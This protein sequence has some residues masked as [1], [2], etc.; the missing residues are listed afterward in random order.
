MKI[1]NTAQFDV[2]IGDGAGGYLTLGPADNGP[3][4]KTG[5]PCELTISE[6]ERVK[7]LRESA[8]VKHMVK[9]GTLVLS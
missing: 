1:R 4:C 2:Q 9:A 7:A 3:D 8:A 5:H 6:A